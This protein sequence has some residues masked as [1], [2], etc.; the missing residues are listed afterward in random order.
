MTQ[1][2]KELPDVQSEETP[3]QKRQS[4]ELRKIAEMDPISTDTGAPK[5]ERMLDKQIEASLSKHYEELFAGI[6]NLTDAQKESVKATLRTVY[7]E[8]Y[9]NG[10]GNGYVLGD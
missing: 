5:Q 1:Q 8:A 3:D 4:E 7:S 9:E 10:L 2:E 6:P